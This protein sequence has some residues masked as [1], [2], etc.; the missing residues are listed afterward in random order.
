VDVER[1]DAG[2]SSHTTATG[3]NLEPAADV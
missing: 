1:H 2:S 3:S